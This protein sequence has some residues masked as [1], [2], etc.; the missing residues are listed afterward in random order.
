MKTFSL[1]ELCD[2]IQDVIEHELPER[3][4]VCAEVGSMST[5]GHCYMELVEK[6]ENGILAAKV[7]ATCWSN[8]YTLLSAYFT[9]ETGQALRAGMQ[10]LIEVSI[11]FHAV[12]GL[13]LNIWNIDPTYTIGDLAKQR[14]AT[15]RRLTEEGVMELQQAL[16][17]PSLPRRVAVVS[18]ADAAGYEDFCNQLKHN[19]FGFAFHTHLYPAVMQGDTAP[20]SIIGALNEIASVE[21]EWDVVVIIRGGG[22]SSDL[23]CFDDYDLANHCAQFPLPIIAGI[24]HTR[25]VSVVDMVTHT[26]VKTPT[27][28][29]EHLIEHIAMQVEHVGDLLARLRNATQSVVNKEKNRLLMYP[30]RMES[31][32][33]RAVI[34]EQGKLSLWMKTIELHSPERIFNMGYS[35]TMRNG[36]IVKSSRDVESGD[37]IETYLQDGTIH[38]VVK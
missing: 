28:A 16:T 5:R 30:Q 37:T 21:D 25:D 4:W 31:A 35:L 1:R 24:G 34:K 29:A 19:R 32:I 23:G 8:V 17:I 36:K 10:V 11:E 13:S 3:Y 33:R 18:S 26:S 22:A 9:Q 6:G 2:C 14:Q 20:K 38:S 27:A 15:I 12:Y 7:R